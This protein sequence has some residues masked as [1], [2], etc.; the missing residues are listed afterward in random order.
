MHYHAYIHICVRIYIDNTYYVFE[1]SIYNIESSRVRRGLN[2]KR[3][4]NASTRDGMCA[5]HCLR[6]YAYAYAYVYLCVRSGMCVTLC[7]YTWA[8]R[9]LLFVCLRSKC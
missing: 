3:S 7:M 8:S 9:A 1:A 5:Y 2:Y 6:L 4:Y